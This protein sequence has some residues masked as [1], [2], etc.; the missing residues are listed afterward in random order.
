VS[1]IEAGIGAHQRRERFAQ[2]SVL[3]GM[4][5]EPRFDVLHGRT[6]TLHGSAG[7]AARQ[8]H[9]RLVGFRAGSLGLGRGV[10]IV[11]RPL[12]ARAAAE[13]VAQPDENHDREHQKQKSIDIESFTH[14]LPPPAP[15]D[16]PRSCGT[17]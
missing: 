9:H 8:R 3:G 6:G 1:G 16:C 7:A 10:G 13:H 12:V 15:I 4:A 11:R 17:L 2:R 14:A 5:L